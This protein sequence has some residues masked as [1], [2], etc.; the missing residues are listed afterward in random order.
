MNE[1]KHSEGKSLLY[2]VILQS[3]KKNALSRKVK[4]YI[5]QTVPDLQKML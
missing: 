3:Y 5:Q 1:H 4:L 2:L